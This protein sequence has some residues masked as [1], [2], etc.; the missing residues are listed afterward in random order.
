MN[1]MNSSEMEIKTI[2][3][4]AGFVHL[5]W[6][7]HKAL[8]KAVQAVNETVALAETAITILN[9][10]EL[11]HEEIGYN[12]TEELVWDL[13][14]IWDSFDSAVLSVNTTFNR[15]MMNGFQLFTDELRR[16]TEGYLHEGQMKTV[17]E[18]LNTIMPRVPPII[19]KFQT[20]FLTI[21]G[22]FHH[23]IDRLRSKLV[24]PTKP[25]K[26]YGVKVAGSG[27]FFILVTSIWLTVSGFN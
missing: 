1:I 16:T 25:G 17:N 15:M 23:A 3:E 5:S 6:E 21:R 22:G 8:G 14:V 4:A 27:C 19:G 24:D 26:S 9:D 10:L 12:R 20:P 13:Q 7:V 18:S 2:M 11:K